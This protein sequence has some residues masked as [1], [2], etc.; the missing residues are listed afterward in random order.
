MTNFNQKT[1]AVSLL[2]FISIIPPTLSFGSSYGKMSN[3]KMG[4]IETIL[5]TSWVGVAYSLI[6]GMPMCIIGSTGPALAIMT[7]IKNMSDGLGCEYL[8]FNA[9]VSVWVFI[10][11]VIC[12]FFDITRYVKLATRFTDEIFALLIV[13]IFIVKALGDP[14]PGGSAGLFRYL[15]EGHKSHGKHEDDEDY[16][17]Q[18]VAFLSII[19][20]FGTT[21]LIFFFRSFKFSP[22]FCG[23]MVR[24]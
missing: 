19:L 13:V 6:G 9:W 15:E 8:P 10:Y 5:A 3:N 4:A 24:S 11:T 7:A 17:Y 2:L 20:G 18:S 12:G 1:V 23:D 14:F 16:D 22:Y 21:A